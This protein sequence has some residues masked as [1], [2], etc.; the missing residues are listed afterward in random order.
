MSP[1]DSEKAAII[2]VWQSELN[3]VT[4]FL[5]GTQKRVKMGI[6]LVCS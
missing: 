3:N 6:F 5:C 4:V 2:L 1:S